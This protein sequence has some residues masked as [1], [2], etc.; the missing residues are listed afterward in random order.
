[1]MTL[2]AAQERIAELE[3]EV[4]YLRELALPASKVG[5]RYPAEWGLT[6]MNAKLLTALVHGE[7]G[8]PIPAER[9][10]L[11]LF[12]ARDVNPKD[13]TVYVC[14]L[15]RFLKPLGMHIDTV[16]FEGYRLPPAVLRRVRESAIPPEKCHAR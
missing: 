9:L 5:T 6:L 10:H 2:A 7:P 13:I 3:T 15:R 14:N 12:G 4:A 16:K 1:M 11:A 8:V